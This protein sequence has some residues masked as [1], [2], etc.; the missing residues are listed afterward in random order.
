MTVDTSRWQADPL[1]APAAAPPKPLRSGCGLR[2]ER[3][4]RAAKGKIN[5]CRW[6]ARRYQSRSSVIDGFRMAHTNGL[7]ESTIVEIQQRGVFHA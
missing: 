5:I 6:P 1:L 7:M 4:W 2:A 3:T